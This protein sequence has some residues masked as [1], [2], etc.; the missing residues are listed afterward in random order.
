[1]IFYMKRFM[2]AGDLWEMA[3]KMPPTIG[4]VRLY[5]HFYKRLWRWKLETK[6]GTVSIMFSKTIINSWIEIYWCKISTSFKRMSCCAKREGNLPIKS[7]LIYIF[8]AVLAA[9]VS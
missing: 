1:M 2:L 9:D 6:N 8:C 7:N 5:I 4:L 3:E